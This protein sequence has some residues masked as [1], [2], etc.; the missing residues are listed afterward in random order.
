MLQIVDAPLFSER[1][2]LRLGGPALAEVSLT[3]AVDT[4]K[5]PRVLSELGGEP[6]VLGAGSNILAADG[7]HERVLI[8]PYFMQ[9]PSIQG[10]DGPLTLVR[11]GS[12]VRLPRLLGQC[13][14]WGLS[15]LEGLCG[16]PGTVGGA[17]AMNAGS[18]GCETGALVHSLRV[19]SP[20][21]GVVDIDAE[22][23]HFSYR[24]CQIAGLTEWFLVLQI[25]FGLTLAPRNVITENMR[26]NILKKK[27][28]QPVTAWS[29]GCVFKNPSQQQPAGMLLEQ[30]GF[31]G[32]RLGGMAFSDVH[33]NFLIN[34]GQG[35][36]TAAMELMEQA[37]EAVL[38]RFDVVLEPEVRVLACPRA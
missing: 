27:S 20:A 31:K 34:E 15:G 23:L 1:T 19:Y 14:Q 32:R 5:L 2:T 22:Y 21:T 8:R 12:G 4:F 7:R 35:S 38:R 11:V 9:A 36:A 17:V 13:A 37:R 25:I 10:Q 28:T 33:A 3:E 18:F 6:L 29:A 16:I 24:H 26:H 30:V